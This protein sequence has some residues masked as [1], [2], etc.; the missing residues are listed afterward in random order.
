MFES[1]FKLTTVDFDGVIPG[2]VR[3]ITEPVLA[4][5][6][7]YVYI[8]DI[9]ILILDEDIERQHLDNMS[10][11]NAKFSNIIRSPESTEGNKYRLSG[12]HFSPTDVQYPLPNLDDIDFSENNTVKGA[13]EHVLYKIMEK[14]DVMVSREMDYRP[15]HGIH[16]RTNNHPF[17]KSKISRPEAS[18]ER[19][20][21]GSQKLSWSGLEVT[22][23]RDSYIKE[24]NTDEFQEIY[25][26]VDIKIR[27]MLT[28]LEN[29]CVGRFTEFEEEAFTYII[30]E[31][32]YE[33]LIREAIRTTY[34]DGITSA[35]KRT[36]SYIHS[37]INKP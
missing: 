1:K 33:R 24:L 10:D 21:D 22:S 35:G 20:S 18:F 7:D 13:D 34:S 8:G 30:M 26:E 36:V 28:V 23:Y 31:A 16:M 19:I 5:I 4:D 3:F 37:L 14:K 11:N 27:N 17:G 6:C 9:D 2:A 15:V 12:L 25:F 32:Y 29:A